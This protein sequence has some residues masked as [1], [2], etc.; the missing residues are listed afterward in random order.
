MVIEI[1]RVTRGNKYEPKDTLWWN[2][3]VQKTISEKKY[4]KHL[5]HHMSDENIQKY[6][7]ARRNAKKVVSE[8][9]GKENTISRKMTK[10][11]SI[12]W[13]SLEKERHKKL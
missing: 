10:M 8:A 11:I 2:D 3:D 4:Y 13:L 9:R 1:F 6:I 5:H 12:R 7:E